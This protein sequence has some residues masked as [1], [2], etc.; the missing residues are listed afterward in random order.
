MPPAD[1]CQSEKPGTADSTS[2][3]L[4]RP[5][6]ASC[7]RPPLPPVGVCFARPRNDRG[8]FPTL[9]DRWVLQAGD[10]RSPLHSITQKPCMGEL[11]SPA[12]PPCRGVLRTPAG[13]HRSPLHSLRTQF[14]Y[15]RPMP[16]LWELFGNL[17]LVQA[18]QPGQQQV[19]QAKRQISQNQ[20]QSQQRQGAFPQL[21]SQFLPT[22]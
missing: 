6:W 22:Q 9:G 18:L 15:Q 2:G 10:H 19:R 20:R 7:A 11:R 5:A 8:P 21:R 1:I 16:A 13:D 17:I 12:A 14:P 3:C 4:P